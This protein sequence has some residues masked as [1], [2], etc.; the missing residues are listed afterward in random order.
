[1]AKVVAKKHMYDKR[2]ERD[3]NLGAIINIRTC[4][5]ITDPPNRVGIRSNENNTEMSPLKGIP[6][7]IECESWTPI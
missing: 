4:Q 1:M 7:G 3:R 2:Y 5:T 6:Q